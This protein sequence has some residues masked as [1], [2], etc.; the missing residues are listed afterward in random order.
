MARA[1]ATRI[2]GPVLVLTKPGVLALMRE[3]LPAIRALIDV[4]N[5]CRT[6]SP[7]N[8]APVPP[9]GLAFGLRDRLHAERRQLHAESRP[10]CPVGDAGT[11]RVRGRATLEGTQSSLFSVDIDVVH[12]SSSHWALIAAGA[13]GVVLMAALA[14]R[15]VQRHISA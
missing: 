6:S 11:Y 3:P 1:S 4:S 2:P 7:G 9:T 14:A 8:R 5:P 10:E 13:L 12:R 15:L